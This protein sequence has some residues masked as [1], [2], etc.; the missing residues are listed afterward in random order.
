MARRGGLPASATPLP[1]GWAG[2]AA[3]ARQAVFLASLPRVDGGRGAGHNGAQDRPGAAQPMTS[4]RAHPRKRSR[5][6]PVAAALRRGADLRVYTERTYAEHDFGVYR[7]FVRDD[8][9][10]I[11]AHDA[12]GTVAGE[13]DVRWRPEWNAAASH[14]D[15]HRRANDPGR[16]STAGPV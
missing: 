10:P 1:V 7:F 11:L 14:V 15:A 8:W 6:A 9:R 3:A 5:P 13:Q 2:I 16:K 4:P 12:Q